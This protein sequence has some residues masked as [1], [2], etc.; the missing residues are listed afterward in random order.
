MT[1]PESAVF[2]VDDDDSVRRSLLR[3]LKANGYRAAAFASAGEFLD[4][5]AVWASPACVL[6]DVFMPEFSGLELQHELIA[7][8]SPLAIVFVTGN[9]DIPMGVK[10]MKAG[11]VNFLSKP[12]NEPELIAAVDEALSRSARECLER[13]GLRELK[14]WEATL[15]PREREVM[16]W[17]VDGRRNKQIANALGVVEKTIKVH[18][19][20]VMTK[21]R[22]GSLP[23]LVR[24]AQ[25]LGFRAPHRQ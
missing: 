11:A 12:V 19:A 9:G 17:V 10:A 20:R 3:L 13:E 5:G 4:S 22:A 25:K 24:A 21:M 8:D 15:T 18:R 14:R 23:D 1:G 7:L 2:L 6:L 16:T